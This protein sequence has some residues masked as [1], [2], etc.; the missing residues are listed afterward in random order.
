MI[1]AHLLLQTALAA[2]RAHGAW[3]VA[4]P[5]A[6]ASEPRP[7]IVYLHGMWSSPEDSCA[8]FEPAAAPHGFLVC[9]RGNAP[10]TDGSG[11]KMWSG[12]YA[13]VAPSVRAALDAAGAMGKLDRSGGGTLAGYS[14]GAYFA[15]EI[16]VHEPG[17]WTGL[18][19]LSM[20]LELDA[21]RLSA[22]GVKRVVLASGDADMAR[23][24]MKELAERLDA[25]G[26][27]ARFISLGPG[28]HELP[29][30][31]DARMTEAVAWVRGT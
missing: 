27:P 30:D 18:V 1:L 20:H 28:G 29:K 14:N 26:L 12:S 8:M 11:G 23:A 7:A 19:L 13:T 21:A 17:R 24:S 22:A 31:M 5:P 6:D 2:L 10:M 25:A 4:Y 16:A 9:P 3:G 15:A